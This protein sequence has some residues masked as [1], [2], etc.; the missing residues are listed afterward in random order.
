VRSL[1]GDDVVEILG[2]EVT[3]VEELIL[4]DERDDDA[5]LCDRLP[6]EVPAEEV[7]VDEVEGTLVLVADEERRVEEA[8]RV[9]PARLVAAARGRELED[10]LLVAVEVVGARTRC[11]PKGHAAGLMCIS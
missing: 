7:E 3:R 5:E 1:E 9:L 8:L 4:V 2:V 10:V 11:G 6:D